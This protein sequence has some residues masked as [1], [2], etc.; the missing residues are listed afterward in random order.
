MDKTKENQEMMINNTI[1]A[2]GIDVS[3]G[4]SMVAI[5][6][7]LGEVVEV[8]F[9]VT[10][11]KT[12]LK[13]LV[14]TIKSL[15]GETRVV[16]ECTGKYY[17][18]IAH[19]LFHEGIFVSTVNAKLIHD[20]GNNSI[21]RVKTDKADSVKIA[22][23]ALNYW[24]ELLRFAPEDEIRF[25]LKTLNRQYEIFVK[26]Q[27]AVKNNLISLLD[28]TF[29]GINALVDGQNS[30]RGKVKWVDFVEKF[31][32]AE[33]VSS[34][35]EKQFVEKFARWSEKN[36]YYQN[37]SKAKEIYAYSKEIVA[38]LPKNEITKATVS[39][40]VEL[41][42]SNLSAQVMTSK[43]MTELAKQLPEY[44]L[45]LSMR[46]VG[47]TL[48]VQLI[49]E[50]GDL[51]RFPKKT[52]LVAYAGLDSPPFQSGHMDAKQRKISK[53]GPPALRRALFQVM[54]GLLRSKPED[55]PV[56]QFLDKKRAEG[57]L[58]KVYMVAGSNKFLRI[59]YAKVIDLLRSL[60]PDEDVSPTT[61][62]E[63]V[64]EEPSTLTN[65]ST[66]GE[67]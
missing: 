26:T 66:T 16:M 64:R 34:L 7:P 67:D 10:H 2:V 43:K 44:E 46:G 13:K 54:E 25:Q 55:D 65:Y 36:K 50:I 5:L 60:P 48:S 53:R 32:H 41:V 29:P 62:L 8:P 12:S 38:T 3:K 37:E 11:K 23:Y 24:H 20:F 57:K 59:Y 18:P 52:S 33:C 63:D 49:A 40:T 35:S 51:S 17:Q 6:R 9:E 42:K 4:K 1:N 39:I 28:Q 58:Y 56:Y 30:A 22:R 19:F 21:R 27:V 31:W 45:V 14:K 15:S 61:K 47:T